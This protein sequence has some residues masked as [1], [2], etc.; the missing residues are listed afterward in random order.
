MWNKPTFWGIKKTLLKL[1]QLQSWSEKLNMKGHGG[2]QVF[3]LDNPGIKKF[4]TDS[5]KPYSK[6]ALKPKYMVWQIWSEIQCIKICRTNNQFER[7]TWPKMKSNETAEGTQ[8]QD[9]RVCVPLG[10]EEGSKGTVDWPPKLQST[11]LVGLVRLPAG[12]WIP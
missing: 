2:L 6:L 7:R 10:K 4:L 5:E 8:N 11:N 12:C 1:H 3:N 9:G